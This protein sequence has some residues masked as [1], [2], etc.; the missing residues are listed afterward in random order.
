MQ[1]QY[2]CVIV[3]NGSFP[4][5]SYALERLR[6]A[7]VII[8]CDGAVEALHTRDFTPSAIIGDMDSIPNELKQ[9][10]ADRIH[11]DKGQE[12][13]D[14][15]KAVQLACRLG[16]KAVL[17]VGATGLRE[18]HTIGNISLL[19]DYIEELDQVEMLTDYGLFTPIQETTTFESR[20][21]QQVS[22]FA[23]YP[24]GKITTEGL[25]WP[26][27]NRRIISWWQ[28]SLNEALGDTFTIHIEANARVI[29]YRV[30]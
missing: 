27:T 30:K 13:N 18:D 17:I 20:P 3:A 28:G 26:I 22:L 19:A 24:E 8:A 21:G 2:N 14:L 10:Y 4:T 16:E 7:S 12:T 25:R 15:T 9:R 23:L 29:V 6:E 5:S 1:K 11:E